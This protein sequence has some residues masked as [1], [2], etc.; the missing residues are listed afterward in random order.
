MDATEYLTQGILLFKI[1]DR[2]FFKNT[3]DIKRTLLLLVRNNPT[4]RVRIDLPGYETTGNLLKR[5]SGKNRLRVFHPF[6][7]KLKKSAETKL[8]VMGTNSRDHTFRV[9]HIQRSAWYS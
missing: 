7:A 2:P 9:P 1:K 5:S 4:N 6:S 8:E 3:T